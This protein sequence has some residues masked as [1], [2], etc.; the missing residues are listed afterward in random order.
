MTIRSGYMITIL[1]DTV[2]AQYTLYWFATIT[3]SFGNIHQDRRHTG[4][5][6]FDEGSDR[7]DEDDEAVFGSR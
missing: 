3:T 4:T 2:D 7:K 6:H 5:I 1:G